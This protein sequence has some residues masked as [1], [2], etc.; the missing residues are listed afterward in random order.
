MVSKCLMAVG[1]H[2]L[3]QGLVTN[4]QNHAELSQWSAERCTQG[5][6]E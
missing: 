6:E 3:S 5:P 1:L 2:T 4:H